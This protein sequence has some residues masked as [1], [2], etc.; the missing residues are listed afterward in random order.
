M[1]DLKRAYVGAVRTVTRKAPFEKLRVWSGD[2][3]R[4]TWLV[5]LLA[6]HDFDRMRALGWPWWTFEAAQQVAEHLASVP[7]AR[8]F[9]W[10][11]GAS[12]LWLAERAAEVHSVEH[13]PEWAAMVQDQA[14][15]HVVVTNV[16]P[17]RPV[18]GRVVVGSGKHG[19]EGLDFTEYCAAI[20]TVPGMFDLIVIDGRAREACL[21]ASITRLAPGGVI[22]FDNVDRERYISAIDTLGDR[23][24]VTTTRGLTPAL[25]Y[26]TRTALISANLVP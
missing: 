13:D 8:V 21:A 26:P 15:E 3:L 16:P 22:V 14:P 25:P 23:I 24:R 9:E 5:S 18:D 12:T 19:F 20:D 17:V 11:S 1:P 2:N 4:R 7:D 10:G 6:I